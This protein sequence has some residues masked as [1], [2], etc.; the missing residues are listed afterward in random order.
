MT[1]N[2]KLFHVNSVGPVLAI[3]QQ[4]TAEAVVVNDPLQ[5]GTDENGELMMMD[6]LDMITEHKSVVFYKNNIIS[7]STPVP[8]L[9]KL[10]IEAVKGEDDSAPKLI[11]P[12]NKIITR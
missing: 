6:Y 3:I 12:D 11:V 10:Y 1:K 2:V 5:L 7:V 9:A 4:E 8:Q